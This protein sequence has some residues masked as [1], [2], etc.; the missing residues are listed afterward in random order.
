MEQKPRWAEMC[1]RILQQC[2]VILGGR[3]ALAKFLNVHP[4]EV[5]VW[6]SGKSGP[7]REVFDKAIDVILAEHDRR[8]AQERAGHAAPRRRSSDAA[9]AN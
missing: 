3:D 5:A 1:A 9:R 4:M 6:T 7:P 2:E 8:A